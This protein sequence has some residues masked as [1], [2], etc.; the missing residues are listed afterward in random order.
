MSEASTFG[1]PP[2]H[3]AYYGPNGT[4][5][6]PSRANT[7]SP[8]GGSGGLG[9]PVPAPRPRLTPEELAAQE[10]AAKPPSGPYRR[11]TSGLR[12]DHLPPPPSRRTIT[13]GA[14]PGPPPPPRANPG[15]PA[16]STPPPPPRAQS[17]VVQMNN[18]EQEEDDEHQYVMVKNESMKNGSMKKDE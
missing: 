4:A 16:R 9:A 15:L 13:P 14:S 11:D 8:V 12:T 7:G 5:S 18:Q 17:V 10:E 2:K 1:P 3:S 6:T